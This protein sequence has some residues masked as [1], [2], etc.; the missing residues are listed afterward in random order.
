MCQRQIYT[1]SLK[2]GTKSLTVG[3]Q[4]VVFNF[5]IAGCVRLRAIYNACGRFSPMRLLVRLYYSDFAAGQRYCQ[6]L[7]QL[8]TL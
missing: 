5:G 7:L 1:V 6:A 4:L 3:N 8:F 2:Q